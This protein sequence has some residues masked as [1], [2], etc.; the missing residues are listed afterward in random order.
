MTCLFGDY[1]GKPGKCDLAPLRGRRCLLIAD[2][3]TRDRNAV[4]ATARALAKLDCGIRLCLPDGEGGYGVADTIA[5]GGYRNM[6]D[7]IR[8]AGI[9][10]FRRRA[11][12]TGRR[13]LPRRSSGRTV[14]R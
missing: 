10:W 9:R 8:K 11:D 12:G 2:T 7:W 6:I 4:L 14:G 3:D 5:E 13:G 1:R